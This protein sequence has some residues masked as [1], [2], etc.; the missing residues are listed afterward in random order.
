[1]FPK[2]KPGGYIGGDDFTPNIW[3]HKTM[4]EP[5][6]VC[7]FAVYFAEAVGATIYALP[8]SQFCLH[9]VERDKFKFI[10][11]TGQYGNL[12]LRGQLAPEAM[13]KLS[14]GERFPRLTRVLSKARRLIRE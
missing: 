2:V 12:Q 6:L 13:L 4:F 9:K 1:V 5:T 11:L 3:Q 14:V 7:P 8:Y 10:D